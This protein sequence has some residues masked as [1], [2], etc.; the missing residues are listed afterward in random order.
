MLNYVQLTQQQYVDYLVNL[1]STA[2]G[3][4]ADVRNLGDGQRTIGYGYTFGRDNNLTLWLAAGITLTPPEVSALQSIDSAQT[5]DQ[6]NTLAEQFARTLSKNEA[7]ALLRQ[8]YPEY[9][10]PA[11]N[12]EMLLSVERAAFVS[13]TYNRGVTVVNQRM[14]GFFDAIRSTN[15]AEA[16][17]EL[18]YNANALGLAAISGTGTPKQLDAIARGEDRGIAKRRFWESQAFGKGGQAW[19]IA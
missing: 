17:F 10:A 8:T 19:L 15:R 13:V 9:E 5:L 4:I 7:M 18:R 14:S 16:W 12:L 3:H 6:K 11:N 1:I 2:E